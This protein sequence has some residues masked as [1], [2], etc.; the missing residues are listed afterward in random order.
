MLQILHVM[1]GKRFGGLEKVFLDD[2]PILERVAAARGGHC[3]AIVRRGSEAERRASF[4]TQSALAFTDWDPLARASARRLVGR[5][6]PSLVIAHGQRAWRLFAAATAPTVP[7]AHFVHKPTFDID[8]TRTHYWC[9]SPHLAALAVERGVAE[10]R[11]RVIPNAVALPDA[12]ASPFARAGAPKI[13][14]AGRLHPKKG[15]DVLIRAMAA[16]KAEGSPA[17]CEIAGEGDERGKLEALIAEL[18]VG[19]R[20]RLVGWRE[21]APAFLADGDVFAFPSYQEGMPLALLEA[22]ASG[23]PAVASRIDGVDGVLRDGIDGAL[24]PPGEPAALAGALG[25]LLAAPDRARAYGS[26]ARNR[27]A[28]E[29]GRERLEATL[30]E[31]VDAALKP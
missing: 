21:D 9:V 17:V 19:D 10:N 4:P 15:Y 12:V 1:L 29:H 2:Q 30:A 14:A 7:I 24:V 16:L 3:A 6:P 8:N 25:A 20:V 22:M 5:L 23:L 26:A 13:V 18:G 27:I 31:A 28:A 11:V